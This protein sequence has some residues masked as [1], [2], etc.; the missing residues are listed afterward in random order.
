MKTKYNFHDLYAYS[1]DLNVLYVEDDIDLLN[2]TKEVLD[3]LFKNVVTATNGIDGMSQYTKEFDLVITDINMPKKDGLS[4][5]KDIMCINP[6]QS[7]VVV[8]AY[9]DSERL[10]ELI[11]EG[12]DCFLMKPM[13]FEKLIQVL[14]KSSKSIYDKKQKKEFLINQSKLASMGEMID[15]IAHQWLQP[16]NILKMQT[17]MLEISHLSDTL[18]KEDI[19]EY[20]AKYY[21]Q[22]DYTIETLNEFRNFFSSNNKIVEISYKQIVQS[23]LV[24]LQDTIILHNIDVSL[25]LDSNHL[26]SVV[27]NEF[28]HIMINIISNAIEAFEEKKIKE[29]KI[30]FNSSIKNDEIVLDIIDNAGGIPED[31]ID[32]IFDEKF[33]TKD[34]GTGVGLYLSSLVIN[35]IGAKIFV[36]NTSDGV[37]FSISIKKS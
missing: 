10:I 20:I 8:S 22:I 14:Y 15:S 24:L 25:N 16:M 29:K 1:H 2:D 6:E 23:V 36:S 12:I 7:I 33:T 13:L 5:I 37:K 19:D 3:R 11:E 4:M 27:P 32:N 17:N 30:I 21:T 9:S 18:T 31:I 28:K 26:I 35:K 34:K